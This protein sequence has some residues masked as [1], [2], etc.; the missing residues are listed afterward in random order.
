MEDIENTQQ[1]TME[2]KS[3][4]KVTKNSKGYNWEVKVYDEDPTKALEKTIE[5]ELI[6]QEKYGAITA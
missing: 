4:V 1:M 3:S 6:C 5:L 2:Q